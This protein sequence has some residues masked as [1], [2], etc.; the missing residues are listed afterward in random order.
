MMTPLT[1]A[2]GENGGTAISSALFCTVMRKIYAYLIN[3]P[4][5]SGLRR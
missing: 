2:Y 1:G 4:C 3:V 5:V